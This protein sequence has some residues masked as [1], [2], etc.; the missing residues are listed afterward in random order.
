MLIQGKNIYVG[1]SDGKVKVFSLY[2]EENQTIKLGLLGIIQ[3][4]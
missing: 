2:N 4:I 1:Q 3:P